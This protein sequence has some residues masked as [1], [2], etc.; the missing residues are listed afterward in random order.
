MFAF[1]LCGC[2][3]CK[4]CT[5]APTELSSHTFRYNLLN[6]NNVTFKEEVYSHY[7]KQHLT[8][9]DDNMWASLIPRKI[10]RE[11]DEFS[12]MMTYKKI[13]N[14]GVGG[15]GGGGGEFLREVSLSDV[16]LDADTIYGRAQQTNLEYL[17]MLDVDR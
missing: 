1:M 15:G 12:W 11:G 13:K 17:L 7:H 14:S 2:V 9:T 16:R 3:M 8:P 10:L 4:E 5:N 6:S